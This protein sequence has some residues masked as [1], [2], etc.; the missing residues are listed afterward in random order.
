MLRE[1][2]NVVQRPGE[3]PR[4]WFH[5]PEEDL[6][7]WFEGAEAVRFEY[8]YAHA[9]A[10]LAL[11]WTA[12]GGLTSYA[13]DDGESAGVAKT[14]PILRQQSRAGGLD[15]ASAREAFAVSAPHLPGDIVELVLA[16]FSARP[17]A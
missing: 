13:V 14:T 6:Y 4:R 8:H 7:A 3:L 16:A 11:V 12:A 9:R 2:P 17:S 5:S 1:I 15:L 10:K